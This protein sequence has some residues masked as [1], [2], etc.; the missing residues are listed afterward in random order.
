MVFELFIDTGRNIIEHSWMVST[1]IVKYMLIAHLLVVLKSSN[2]Q[3]FELD[4]FREILLVYSIPSVFFIVLLGS[5]TYAAGIS[6]EPLVFGVLGEFLAL[7][8]F[9]Y[10]FW[11]Y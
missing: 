11:E 4:S 3:S 1:V 6:V 5:L 7:S 2:F 8:Y 10:L 9:A